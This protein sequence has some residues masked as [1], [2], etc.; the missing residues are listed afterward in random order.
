M[1]Q[2]PEKY[3]YQ[4]NPKLISEPGKQEGAFLIP[5]FNSARVKAFCVA[6]STYGWEHISVHMIK[7]G[8]QQTPTW[9]EMCTI[10]DHFWGPEDA[11]VQY[12]PP[13]SEYV[14][15]HPHVLHL[16]R[17]TELEM[18]RPSPLMVGILTGEL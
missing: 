8:K 13:R 17:P 1:F 10:K 4:G 16:W 5:F 15:N 2:V 12:H 18:P 14:N 11:V 9:K 6:S 3:R 7:D